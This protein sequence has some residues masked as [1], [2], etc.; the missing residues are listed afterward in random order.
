MLLARPRGEPATGG[1]PALSASPGPGRH[2]PP[3]FRAAVLAGPHRAET[4]YVQLGKLGPDDLRVVVEGCGVCGSN[5]PLWQGR[6]WFEYPRAPGAPGH[7][8]WGTVVETGEQAALEPGAARPGDRVAV[9]SDRAFA[10]MV[11]VAAREVVALPPALA[12]LPFP[13]EA[14]GSAFN[15]AARSGFAP[16]CTVCVVGAGFLGTALVALAASA[17]CRVVAVSRRTW[18]LGLASTMGAAHTLVLGDRKGTVAAVEELT[19]GQLCDV[20]VE[21]VGGQSALDLAGELARVRGRLVIAGFHQE[22]P[23]QVDLQ[24]WNWRGIDVVN[25]HERDPSVVLDGIGRAARAVAEGR[26]DPRPLFTHRYPLDGLGQALQ[27]M[28]ERPDGFMKALVM[29]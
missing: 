25:A 14:L 28:E 16:G 17:G 6:P 11:D 21:A 2:R 23:R 19:D 13:G 24:L 12:G 3:S 15:V 26:F 27:A 4:A 8:A 9:L 20:V 18:A 1:G 22:S 10:E 29:P 5:L 7:E